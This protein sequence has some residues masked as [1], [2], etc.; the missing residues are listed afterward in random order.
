MHHSRKGQ[1][2]FIAVIV[3]VALALT[4]AYMSFYRPEATPA[5][6]DA[7]LRKVNAINEYFTEMASRVVADTTIIIEEN[8]GFESPSA[9][10]GGTVTYLG[11][12]IPVW[13]RCSSSSIPEL[14][15]IENV[16]ASR[17]EQ[18]ISQ[19][20]PEATSVFDQVS[21]D[22]SKLSVSAKVR[23]DSVDITITLPTQFN[24]TAKYDYNK[25]Y[26][27]SVPS[28]LGRIYAFASDFS[29]SQGKER[30]FESFLLAAIYLSPEMVDEANEKT[31]PLLPTFDVFASTGKSIF[32]QAGDMATYLAMD[33][34]YSI[35]NVML[36][37]SMENPGAS[38]NPKYF[39]IADLSGKRY[40][41][42][43]PA[44]PQKGITFRMADNLT[45][46]VDKDF[47]WRCEGKYVEKVECDKFSQEDEC[48]TSYD[49]SYP[50]TYPVVVSVADEPLGSVF[51]FAVVAAISDKMEPGDC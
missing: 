36:W 31:D 17:V 25:P 39:A 43:N 41:D 5:T 4:V 37:K 19:Y 22:F 30:Y 9:S 14:S 6:P 24:Q 51:R 28:A 27:M 12:K 38:K 8:G 21:F 50:V 33:M 32:R 16:I 23:E 26:N 7:I 11:A 49:V 3:F 34:N 13:Q 44:G 10:S 29:A 40:E 2:E 1:V 48:I 46:T 18:Y 15:T 47:Q 42:L 20:G 35:T 45:I